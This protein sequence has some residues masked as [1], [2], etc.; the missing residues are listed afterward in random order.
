MSLLAD[1]PSNISGIEIGI[2]I[3]TSVTIIISLIALVLETRRQ[4]R[5][6]REKGID[7]NARN[8]AASHMGRVLENL[9][10]AFIKRIVK[11]S[12]NFENK[13]DRPFKRGGEEFLVKYIENDDDYLKNRK[14][15]LK[16]LKDAVG[17]FF[18]DL[19][20]LKY[21]IIPVMDTLQGGG[22]L[23]AALK[24]EISDIAKQSD[25]LGA[26]YL[27]L[28]N[29]YDALIEDINASENAEED[30]MVRK[31]IV[32]IARDVDY[33]AFTIN[34]VPSEDEARC[35]ELIEKDELKDEIVQTMMF[36]MMLSIIKNPS[37][38]R[39][40]ILMLASMQA[41]EARIECKEI[42][43]NIS[44]IYHVLISKDSGFKI[45]DIVKKYKSENYFALDREIR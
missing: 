7:Q 24:K 1:F 4:T 6:E 18:E 17:E 38:I 5:K 31:R 25:S 30:E 19:H 15:E 29:E 36:N 39:V 20:E 9:S 10:D 35:L 32:D 27:S 16:E 26:G 33:W 44:A 21:Q 42:L 28:M 43:C 45:S 23:I 41:Q 8:V 22:E 12:V 34:F 37:R 2:D 11:S 40:K 14:V 3:A 13:V